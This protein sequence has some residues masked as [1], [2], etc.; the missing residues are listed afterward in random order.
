MPGLRVDQDVAA[1]TRRRVL[2][3]MAAAGAF[4]AVDLGSIAYAMGRIGGTG[5]LTPQKFLDR[6]DLV[7]GRHPGFRANHAKGVAV[8]GHFDSNGNARAVSTAEIFGR[9]L[10][11]PVVGRFSLSGGV[12]TVSDSISAPRGLGVAF[13][14]SGQWRTAMMNLPVFFDNS[15][16]GFYERIL[17]TRV[18]AG[19][20]KPD[21]VAMEA[22]L[23]GH[24]ESARA[25]ELIRRQAPTS[26]FG[27]STYRSLNAF[28]LVDAAG[29]RTP[30]RWSLVPM[31]RPAPP[32]ARLTGPNA[33]F[34]ELIRQ[35]DAGP[36]VWRMLLTLGEPS[37]A[38]TD[39]TV[40]WPA[41]RHAIEAGTLTLTA[42][43]ADLPPDAGDMNFDPLV[44]PPGIE[45]SA[46]PLLS[47]RSA[48]YTASFRRRAADH[49]SAPEVAGGD[50]IS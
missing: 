35:L 27:D 44:L 19:T 15:P 11:T 5:R 33:L 1:V 23:A 10:R 14:P 21:P 8:A 32:A 20:G 3:G 50:V 28:Y 26:G 2:S 40:P 47:A 38:V 25:M 18:S 29:T 17:A 37:D 48:V 4:L 31:R 7:N 43:G 6:F 36:L 9:G 49:I 46:D 30:V 13:G 22:F 41:D 24:P 16:Q 39:A 42:V 12:P 45:P 34:G